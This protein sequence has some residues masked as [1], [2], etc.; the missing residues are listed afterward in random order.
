MTK[1]SGRTAK[2]EARRRIDEV[3]AELYEDE[4]IGVNHKELS[5]ALLDARDTLVVRGRVPEDFGEEQATYLEAYAR[6]S[7]E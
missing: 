1:N 7:D 2:R 3:V 4:D 6:E 5:E